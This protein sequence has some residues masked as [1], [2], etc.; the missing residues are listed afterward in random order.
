MKMPS[1]QQVQNAILAIARDKDRVC[2]SDLYSFLL[3]EFGLYAGGPAP[4]SPTDRWRFTALV[5]SARKR[6]IG[7]QLLHRTEDT[8]FRITARGRAYLAMGLTKLD[9]LSRRALASVPADDAAARA[10]AI[11]VN[12]I[13]ADSTDDGT[14]E[15]E[16]G[17]ESAGTPA[18]DI[19]ALLDQADLKYL[20]GDRGSY[21]IPIE[22]ARGTWLVVA[23]E[24]NGWLCLSAHVL[25]LPKEPRAKSV[26]IEGALTMNHAIAVWRFSLTKPSE[27]RLEAEY[28]L[29]HID[30]TALRGLI[31]M[32]EGR[33][34]E[35]CAKL[36]RL[37]AEAQPLDALEQAF[38]RSA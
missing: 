15:D 18:R 21:I 9:A 26:V 4:L 8:S 29:E 20:A 22:G 25:N 3:F 27:L 7:E 35:D 19:P 14:E 32:L 36:V 12:P 5:V 24:S 30:G 33:L 13:D 17:T 2:E 28:R 16:E 1:P 10:A 31:L 11:P 37:G 38:K 34:S 6:L 23:R